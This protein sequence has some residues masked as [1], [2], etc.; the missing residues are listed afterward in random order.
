LVQVDAG[1][2]EAVMVGGSVT[3]V[4]AAHAVGVRCIGLANRRC[5]TDPVR[6]AGAEAIIEHMAELL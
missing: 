4:E 2:A 5:K 3:D 1:A 6:E